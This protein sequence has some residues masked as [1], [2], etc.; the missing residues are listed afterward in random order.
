MNTFKTRG[1]VI[2]EQEYKENDKLLWIFTEDLGKVSVI[3]KGARKSKNKNFSC[4]MTFC[5]GE[6]VLYKGRAMY[7]LNEGR[8]IDSFQD[9]LDDYD[10]LIYGSYFTELID[11]AMEEEKSYEVFVNLIKCFYLMKNKAVDLE[12]LARAFELKLLKASGYGLNLEKCAVCGRDIKV[13]SFI[14]YQFYGGICENCKSEYVTKV[15]GATYNGLKFL[16]KVNL[17][18]T[19][20]LTLNDD[21]KEEMSKVLQ[22]IINLNFRRSPKSLNLLKG[23][24]NN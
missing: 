1:M 6:Y 19:G 12:V 23:F 24:K 10:T 5:F 20:R 14:S 17:E 13:S 16:N 18:S 21:V 11:I 22:T 9:I 4:T 2:K 7:T 8:I 3:A 15:S